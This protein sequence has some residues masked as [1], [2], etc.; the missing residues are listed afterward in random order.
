M[1]RIVTDEEFADPRANL[2]PMSCLGQAIHFSQFAGVTR[3][4][5]DLCL[6][7]ELLGTDEVLV[8]VIRCGDGWNR[9]TVRGRDPVGT[10]SGLREGLEKNP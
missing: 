3:V 5:V 7:A 4:T 10:R 9:T 2:I 8:E 1:K 6:L